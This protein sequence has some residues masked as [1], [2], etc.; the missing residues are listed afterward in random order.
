MKIEDAN[1]ENDG[2]VMFPASKSFKGKTSNNESSDNELNQ[3]SIDLSEMFPASKNFP[4]EDDLITE[5]LG[6]E[7]TWVDSTDYAQLESQITQLYSNEQL[8]DRLSVNLK[9]LNEASNK[10]KYYMDEIDIFIV[11]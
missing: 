7:E 5:I 4:I 3:E 10:M 2:L 1:S 11:K 6:D 8:L 9:K